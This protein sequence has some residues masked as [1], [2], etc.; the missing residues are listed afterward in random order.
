VT[1]HT[2]PTQEV[3]GYRAHAGILRHNAHRLIADIETHGIREPLEIVTDGVHA[4][5]HDGH[6]RLLIATQLGL[7]QVPVVIIRHPFSRTDNVRWPI[8]SGLATLLSAGESG[9]R[10]EDYRSDSAGGDDPAVA[11]CTTAPSVEKGAEGNATPTS[12]VKASYK[13]S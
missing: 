2:L 5:L 10:S 13:S 1:I 3:C 11:D 9:G 12:A 8:R 6:Q 4:K 7:E